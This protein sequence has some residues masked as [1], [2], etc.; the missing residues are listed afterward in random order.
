[1]I[2][3]RGIILRNLKYGETSLIVDIFTEEKGLASFII[4]GVRKKKAKVNASLMQLMT[5][6]DMVAYHRD[7]KDLHRIK[8]IKPAYI[9]TKIPFDF[10]RGSIG[11]FMTELAK[12]SIRES[13]ENKPLF[14]FLYHSFV[15]LDQTENPIHNFHLKFMLELTVYLGFLPSG[16]QTES[17]PYF[18]LQNG[19]FTEQEPLHAYFLDPTLSGILS[20]LLEINTDDVHQ[21]P[22]DRVSRNLMLDKLL[23]FY[24]LHIEN[25]PEINTHQVLR[26]VLS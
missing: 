11:L 16:I 4:S 20:Q 9:Y 2:K 7:D 10:I 12:K 14:D 19:C 23:I 21:I 18:D 13:E 3:T 22:I 6:V 5:L 8:E 17:Q 25:L 1:M 26:D 15:Y 24:K